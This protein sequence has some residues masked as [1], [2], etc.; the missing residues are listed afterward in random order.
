MNKIHY[1]VTTAVLLVGTALF[2]SFVFVPAVAPYEIVS[3]EIPQN[4]V[5]DEMP[6]IEQEEEYTPTLVD[7]WEMERDVTKLMDAQIL[8][9]ELPSNWS[10]KK[11]Y[12]R[13][14]YIGQY[15]EYTSEL[16]DDLLLTEYKWQKQLDDDGNVVMGGI[17][18]A[19]DGTYQLHTHN[20]FTKGER[21]FLLGDLLDRYH[22]NG[23][24]VGTKIKFGDVVLE[25]VWE[26]DIR[27][28]EGGTVPYANLII[29]TC[30]ERNGDRRLI[31][32]W[33]IVTE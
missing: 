32:G 31:T 5:E 11:L 28:L 14:T 19:K 6:I 16:L 26:K 4:I 3:V 18:L 22:S 21:F 15:N 17:V 24:L 20:T 25:S 29:S 27:I 9:R 7:L 30:L 1:I 2:T 23:D 8:N 13:Y 10:S 12:F 33:N